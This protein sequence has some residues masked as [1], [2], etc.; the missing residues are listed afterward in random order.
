MTPQ[1]QEESKTLVQSVKETA[2]YLKERPVHDSPL[3][4]N[5]VCKPIQ[6]FAQKMSEEIISQ[7]LLLCW[8]KEINYTKLPFID[9]DHE[10]TI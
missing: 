10:Y 6:N 9:I 2:G 7:A 8:Q 3:D 4:L 1:G 5:T